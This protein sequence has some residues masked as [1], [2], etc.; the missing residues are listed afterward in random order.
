MGDQ[1]MIPIDREDT[2]DS[3][4]Q[5][6][7][8]ISLANVRYIAVGSVNKE[9]RTK[10]GIEPRQ[11]FEGDIITFRDI[12][13][14]FVDGFKNKLNEKTN[15]TQRA[16]VIYSFCEKQLKCESIT[17]LSQI[18]DT[19]IYLIK[20]II[21]LRFNKKKSIK[22]VSMRDEKSDDFKNDLLPIAE[23]IWTEKMNE[24]DMEIKEFAQNMSQWIQ[25]I[26]SS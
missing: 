17:E 11:Y 20:I 16:L 9:F 23:W 2:I 25:E 19:M 8:Q 21:R 1:L 10:D 14:G 15:M 7:S 26:E 22:N 4:K 3:L 6:L 5:Q 18:N 13:I 24:N 12:A